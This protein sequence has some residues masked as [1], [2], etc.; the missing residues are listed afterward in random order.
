MSVNFNY[1]EK[2]VLN[3]LIKLAC[4]HSICDYY[5][6]GL[7]SEPDAQYNFAFHMKSEEIQKFTHILQMELWPKVGSRSLT[8]RD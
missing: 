6:V 3:M 4:G 8:R 2:C 5:H 7:F 1:D